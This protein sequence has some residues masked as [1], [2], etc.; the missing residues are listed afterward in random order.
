[1]MKVAILI[2]VLLLAGM[3]LLAD[4]FEEQRTMLVDEV[5]AEIKSI[6]GRE[7]STP[8]E[9]AMRSVERHK[10]VPEYMASRAYRNTPLPIGREQTISQP[11]IVALMTELLDPGPDDV[12]LEVGTGSGYQAAVLAEI[13]A[14]V[15]SVEIIEELARNATALLLREG[16]TN[17]SVRHGDGLLGWPKHAPFDGIIV[18]AAGIEIPGELL[19]QLAPGGRLVMPVGPTGS[20]QQLKLIE[21]TPDAY[22]HSDVLPVR[23]VP[24][25]RE[26]R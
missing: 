12:V 17:V 3:P 1:M 24:V 21:K 20:V 14:G 15:Y 18:T 26:V 22:R 11:L 5:A 23:F 19:D 25:T 13:V 4:Q 9:R 8:V 10:F 2:A 6:L 16:Y 7:L